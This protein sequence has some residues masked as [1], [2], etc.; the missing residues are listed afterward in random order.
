[1]RNGEKNKAGYFHNLFDSNTDAVSL[2][3][4]TLVSLLN[5]NILL[6]QSFHIFCCTTN[7]DIWVSTGDQNCSKTPALSLS[8]SSSSA[9]KGNK[10][11]LFPTIT[12]HTRQ[13]SPS[14]TS[15]CFFDKR[16]ALVLF[17]LV[18]SPSVL[19]VQLVIEARY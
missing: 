3:I 10:M 18:L 6:R 16:R 2:H 11:Q 7:L 15:Q 13:H 4:T 5:Y 14:L 9:T 1:M 17:F 8:Y 19:I 12:L